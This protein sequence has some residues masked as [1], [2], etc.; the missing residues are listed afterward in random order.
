MKPAAGDA[1]SSHR[2]STTT[3]RS[4]PGS[5]SPVAWLPNRCTLALLYFWVMQAVIALRFSRTCTT[6]ANWEVEQAIWG[7]VCDLLTYCFFDLV[8]GMLPKRAVFR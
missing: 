7:A 3:S 4:L 8:A 1:S 6:W 2:P 5:A